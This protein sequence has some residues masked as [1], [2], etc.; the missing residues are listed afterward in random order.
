MNN[1]A[2]RTPILELTNL[3]KTFANKV[4][5]KNI[6]LQVMKNDI[7][8][9]VG[10]SGV[11]KT[12]LLRTILGLEPVDSGSF[13]FA[14]QVFDPADHSQNQIGIVFQDYRLFPNLN[15]LENITLAPIQAQKQTPAAAVQQADRLLEFLKLTPQRKLYP[16]QLSGGQKQRVAIARALILE[17]QILCYDEP[18][19]ALDSSN[20][21]QVAN[22]LRQFQKQG[23]TQLVVTHDDQF[24]QKISSDIFQM[25]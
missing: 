2:T 21:W 24:A 4:I 13:K 15:V 9:I 1:V 23:M 6:N 19:S 16:F 14:G 17:P 18:T 5:F 7:L 12:T 20:K 8:S 10:P 11:G 3:S 25:G 22:L